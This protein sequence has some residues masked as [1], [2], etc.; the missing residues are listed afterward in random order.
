MINMYNKRK[1]LPREVDSWESFIVGMIDASYRL[2]KK[3]IISDCD[4]ILTD[5]NIPCDSNGK[6]FKIYGCHDK[7]LTHLMESAGWEFL[8]VT[9]DRSGYS[10][11]SNRVASS[12]GSICK[13]ADAEEREELVRK[14]KEDGYY[15]VFCGDSPSDLRAASYADLACTT[16]N[17]FGPIKEYFDYVS[18]HDGGHGGFAEILWWTLKFTQDKF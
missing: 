11:T 17:C 3:I 2:K 9:N 16:R 13:T 6:P 1:V 4:G 12:L 7:E 5:G 18:E 8:F 15:V 10:I 14:Y